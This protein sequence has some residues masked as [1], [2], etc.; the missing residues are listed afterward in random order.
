MITGLLRARLVDR[1]VVCVAP[2]ILGAG[3]EAVG[4]LGISELTR[5][6]TMTDTS[7]TPYGVD[8]V[9]D[10]R[11]RYPGNPAD[12]VEREGSVGCVTAS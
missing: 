8:L 6:L 5:V 12:A 2:K 11:V 10:G 4:D 9:L 1:L 7:V 3:I